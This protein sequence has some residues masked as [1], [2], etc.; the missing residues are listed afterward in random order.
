MYHEKSGNTGSNPLS[1]ENALVSAGF[2]DWLH[3]IGFG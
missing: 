2:E 1:P 3:K